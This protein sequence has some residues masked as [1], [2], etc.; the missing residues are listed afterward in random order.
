MKIHSLH[1]LLLLLWLIENSYSRRI[2][3][4]WQENISY[5]KIEF[6]LRLI[7]KNLSIILEAGEKQSWIH[8]KK[9]LYTAVVDNLTFQY[10]ECLSLACETFALFKAIEN[11]DSQDCP[12]WC[13]IWQRGKCGQIQKARKVVGKCIVKMQIR[14]W[15]PWKS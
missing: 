15:A 7:F 10:S 9:S 12:R 4:F 6:A 11:V 13:R 8:H 3:R 2:W 5:R 14:Y 1:F